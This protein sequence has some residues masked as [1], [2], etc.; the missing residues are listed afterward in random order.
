[1]AIDGRLLT[2]IQSINDL[3]VCTVLDIH[4]V[5]GISRPAVHRM[6][7]SLCSYGF[8][9]RVNGSSAIRLT[10]QI[11]SLSAGYRTGNRI[12]EKAAPVLAALQ[13]ELRWPLSFATPA[14]DAMVIQET[15][16]DHNPFVF[17]SGRIGLRLPMV[18]TAMGSAYLAHCDAEEVNAVFERWREEGGQRADVERALA[19]ARFRIEQA[20]ENGFAMRTGGSPKRTTSI[21]VPVLVY[22]TPVGA[23]CTTCPTSALSLDEACAS[24]VPKLVAA[25]RSIAA[26]CEN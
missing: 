23:L 25:A 2:V 18:T 11:L 6:V 20:R 10:S 14:D 16:R 3:G 7:D 22:A 17:D 26:S 4:R 12:A 24:F 1:M 5:T 21:A 19:A 9:E 8:T 13:A 15:T